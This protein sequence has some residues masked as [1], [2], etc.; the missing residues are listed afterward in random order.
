MMLT[1]ESLEGA[2][3]SWKRTKRREAL[4]ER[5]NTISALQHFRE[6]AKKKLS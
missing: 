4:F 1:G 6:G 2:T 5:S 3:V